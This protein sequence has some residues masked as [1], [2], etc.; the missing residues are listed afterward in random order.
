MKKLNLELNEK[1]YKMIEET[2]EYY[3]KVVGMNSSIEKT[4][5]EIIFAHYMVEV[6]PYTDSKQ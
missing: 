5:E 4:I 6:A 2:T 3:N 1:I